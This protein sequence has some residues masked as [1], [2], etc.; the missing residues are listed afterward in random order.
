VHADGVTMRV[1][2]V[3][4]RRSKTVRVTKMAESGARGGQNGA[5]DG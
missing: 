4:G 3:L 2:S 5:E 1:L